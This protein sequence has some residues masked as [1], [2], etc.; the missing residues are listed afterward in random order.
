MEIHEKAWESQNYLKKVV[1]NPGYM[2]GDFEIVLETVLLPDAGHCPNPMERSTQFP[3]LVLNIG[4][5]K[6]KR[7]SCSHGRDKAV[8]LKGGA[9]GP[10]A[11]DWTN[12]ADPVMTCYKQASFFRLQKSTPYCVQPVKSYP[13][14]IA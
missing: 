7:L 10:L 9:R 6:A 12:S 14:C 13:C 5:P 1:T 11:S 8:H 4:D 2:K 3:T